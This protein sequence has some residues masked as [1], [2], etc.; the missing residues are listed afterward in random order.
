MGQENTFLAVFASMHHLVGDAERARELIDCTV[1][2][3]SQDYLLICH[4]KGVLDGW[5]LAEFSQRSRDWHA[6]HTMSGDLPSRVARMAPMLSEE[7]D[8]SSA[9]SPTSDAGSSP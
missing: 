4:I 3:H 2:R 5:T 6:S 1:K 7:I 9:P 8:H